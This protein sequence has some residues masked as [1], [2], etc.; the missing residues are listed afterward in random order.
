[1]LLEIPL[2]KSDQVNIYSTAENPNG[3]YNRT[4]SIKDNKVLV[5]PEPL[6]KERVYRAKK[7]EE[8]KVDIDEP[9]LSEQMVVIKW[10]WIL[11]DE[12]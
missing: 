3:I 8:K 9:T 5:F 4:Q 12:G 10:W 2:D 1:V 7:V 11:I 6:H